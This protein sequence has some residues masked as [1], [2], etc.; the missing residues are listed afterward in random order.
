MFLYLGF[1][2][3][4]TPTENTP[5]TIDKARSA[6]KA[7]LRC[8]V[9]ET[10]VDPLLLL[11]QMVLAV[12]PSRYQLEKETANY[13]QILLGLLREHDDL[14]LALGRTI[15]RLFTT[16]R[17]VS[18]YTDSGMLPDTGFFSEI[19]RILTHKVLPEL[20]DNEELR[21]C[22]AELFPHA[23]D[24][25]WFSYLP[26]ED[27]RQLWTILDLHAVQDAESLH[28]MVNQMLEAALVL[29]HRIAAMGLLPELARVYPRLKQ[30][31]S[32]FIAM[33]LEVG[34]FVGAFHNA[35]AG[36]GDMDDGQQVFVLLE[37]CQQSLYKIH[38]AASRLGTSMDLSFTLRR[39]EQHLERLTLLM[40]FVTVKVDSK[41]TDEM[42]QRWSDFMMNGMEGERSHNSLKRHLSNMVSLMAL[43]ITDNA[44]HTGE[45]Y[46]ASS[47]KEWF[48]MLYRAGGAGI[49]IAVLAFLKIQ[50][51]GL[52]LPAVP[53]AWLNAFIY[54]S[55]FAVIYMLNF[56]IATKQPAMTA[57]TLAGNISH[58]TGRIRD[59]EKIVDL[60]V[61]TFR[62][63]LAAV[64]GNVMVAL[65]L[66][67]FF[68]LFIHQNS[69]HMPIDPEKAMRLLQEVRPL[70]SFSLVYA[71][72]AGVWLFTA[73]LV[74]GYLDNRAVYMQLG[75]RV[76][77]LYWLRWLLGDDQASRTGAYIEKHAGGLGGNIFFGLM[78]GLTPLL[79]GFL[80][81]GLDIRHIAFS[82]A[83]VG[84][85]LV[86]LDFHVPLY[87]WGGAVLGVLSIGLV[88]LS[89]SFALALWIAMR[90]RKLSFWSL[91]PVM[92]RF[93]RRLLD[94]PGSFFLPPPRTE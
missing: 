53:Q 12:Q 69:G 74:S 80:G 73:G 17:Q 83:N 31:E 47:R 72:I 2:F 60:M 42:V 65:P 92:P 32:P 77:Q 63:Q 29:S 88:N 11:R 55:G 13:W 3:M 48:S 6:I 82:S 56:I 38:S 50:G 86:A 10:E 85:A 68:L 64:A 1:G 44:A 20:R 87:L 62:S 61:D 89:V 19:N 71:A 51:S 15:L 81:I 35:L 70:M 91:A 36:K 78:L 21:A 5:V 41:N 79:G 34:R 94:Y 40:R 4:D 7:S 33:N 76:G 28:A 30:S 57:A 66:A 37:Q 43:R 25:K 26:Y 84:Y 23:K 18:F 54:A 90:S 67:I 22:M 52:H 16:R 59:T 75:V 58:S 39:M 46:I 24:Q 9:T 45:H 8:M 93:F 49:L 27:R 14:R